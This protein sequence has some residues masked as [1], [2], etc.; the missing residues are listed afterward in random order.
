MK[1]FFECSEYP[2]GPH[3]GIGTLIQLLAR[4][5]VERGHGV[6]VAGMYPADYPAADREVDEGV[7]VFRFRERPGRFSW[8]PARIRFFRLL[9][10][11]SRAGEI[12]LIEVPDYGAPAAGWPSL[13]VPV[14]TRLS[15]SGGFFAAE[16]G[17]VLDRSFYLE[18]A[19]LRRSDFWF[20]ESRYMAERTRKLYRLATPPSAIIYNPVALPPPV[21]FENR[22]PSKVVYAGTLTEKKGVIPLIDSWP[23][24]RAAFPQAELHVRGKDGRA[25]QGGSMREFLQ[26]RAGNAAAGGVSFHDQVPLDALIEEFQSARVVVLPSYAE[27]FALTPLHAMAAGCPTIYTRRGSGPELIQDGE[28]GLLVDPAKPDE[29]AEAIMRLLGNEELAAR[30]GSA[31]R[32]HIQQ[33]FSLEKIL[34]ENEHFYEECLRRFDARPASRSAAG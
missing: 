12:D 4:G 16:M 33:N 11:W 29:I 15:G 34:E 8:V 19:S 1:I 3:G 17:R 25:P 26:R 2:P 21:R 5:L 28:N 10:R 14:V 32:H 6:R 13:P 9:S 31:A 24:V 30:L 22:S 23:R 27:G 7:E 18:L 20:S